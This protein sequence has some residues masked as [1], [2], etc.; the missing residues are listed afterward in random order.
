[1][2]PRLRTAAILVAMITAYLPALCAEPGDSTGK[3]RHLREVTV[4]AIGPRRIFRPDNTTGA[5]TIDGQ[6]MNET[7]AFMAVADPV[8][9]VKTMPAVASTNEL[10][11][12]IS[13]RGGGP[14]DNR[15]TADGAPIANPM[16]MLGLFSAYNPDF[17]DHYTF[18]P[19]R[20]PATTASS[21]AGVF[22]A[23]T[24]TEPDSTIRGRLTAGLIESHGAIHVPL[25]P[26]RVS[27]SAG[28]RSTYLSTV[29]P[30][31]LKL[32]SST[33]DYGFTDLNLALK[34]RL[35][36]QDLLKISAIA[37]RDR[38]EA[39][40]DKNGSK[41]G[42]FG[43]SNLATS[44]T[45]THRNTIAALTYSQ[46]KNTFKLNEGGRDLD[47]PSRLTLA[48]ASA[49]TP[50]GSHWLAETDLNIRHTTGQHN[51]ATGETGDRSRTSIEWNIGASYRMST[52]MLDLDAGLRMTL[53]HC[54][55][56]TTLLPQ[57]R[58]NISLRPSEIA[59]PY[60]SY[61]R[62]TTFDRLIQES[63]GG[64]PADFHTCA[65]SDIPYLD[66]HNLE[67]GVSGL[68][69]GVYL[70][71][72][73]EAYYKIMRNCGEYTGSLLDLTNASYNPLSD[74]HTGRG[75]ATGLSVTLMR[76]FGRLRGRISYNI[77][78]SRVKIPAISDKTFPT[79]SD[80]LHDLS[81]TI[82]G[83]PL[84]QTVDSRKTVRR[85]PSFS[86]SICS[87]SRLK[88]P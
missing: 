23:S 1:M 25:M 4:S 18:R 55:H 22:E 30:N 34:A 66:S 85:S 12:N 78:T 11:A 54:H 57:P 8:A 88:T 80:R 60:M 73:I 41:D 27:L 63:N 13:V 26:G 70:N 72:I 21:A 51:R 33:L 35:T 79:A 3:S 47:L 42:H 52:Q 40:N 67:T 74:Y 83:E 82:P 45:W 48:T 16:H 24:T 64:L 2:S 58:V 71:Y 75:Y 6:R 84:S 77:G 68:I 10:Q 59:I 5:I 20:I 50:L 69:P 37:N 28:A 14:G 56:Y 81:A 43:W 29:F 61:S 44:A 7:P 9:L 17:Y 31:L 39:K 87:Q 46:Y 86:S 62:T 32:G 53:Y 76:Q 65:D 15:F 38:M 36:H 49:V 19:G